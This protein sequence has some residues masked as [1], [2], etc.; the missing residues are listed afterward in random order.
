MEFDFIYVRDL[1]LHVHP[2]FNYPSNAVN[3]ICYS[4]PENQLPAYI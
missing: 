1:L 2:Y 4:P 3:A